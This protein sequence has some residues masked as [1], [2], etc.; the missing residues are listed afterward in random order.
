MNDRFAKVRICYPCLKES[1]PEKYEKKKLDLNYKQRHK[2]SELASLLAMVYV[3]SIGNRHI[4]MGVLP[5]FIR[6]LLDLVPHIL[7]YISDTYSAH[8]L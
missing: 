3:I 8:R 1:G 6:F 4:L 2:I 7:I 5:F